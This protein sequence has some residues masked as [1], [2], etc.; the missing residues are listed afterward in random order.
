MAPLRRSSI[1]V[2]A[3]RLQPFYFIR[4]S[5]EKI[6]PSRSGIALSEALPEPFVTN[7]G[8]QKRNS[9]DPMEGDHRARSSWGVLWQE[10]G[11]ML[12]WRFLRSATVMSFAYQ[13]RQEFVGYIGLPWVQPKAF[14]NSSKFWT[15]PLTRHL[16]GE[17][18]STRA[19]WRAA[20]SLVFWHHTWA[21]P[22]K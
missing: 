21:K 16:P 8:T 11:M 3:Y 14:P 7:G 22:M 1:A 20:A 6:T 10:T 2:W 13:T 12:P 15:E 9:F 5:Y 18:G 17:C 19:A 4:H